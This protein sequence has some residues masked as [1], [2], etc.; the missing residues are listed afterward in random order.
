[1]KYLYYNIIGLSL[2]YLYGIVLSFS[3]NRL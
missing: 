3:E 1:M 2:L